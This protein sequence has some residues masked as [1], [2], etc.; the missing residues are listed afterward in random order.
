MLN[1][2][3]KDIQMLEGDFIHDFVREEWTVAL[4]ALPNGLE[5]FVLGGKHR[6]Y[7]QHRGKSR[8]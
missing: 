4:P 5:I 2:F 7:S 8:L 6:F 1:F 3:G